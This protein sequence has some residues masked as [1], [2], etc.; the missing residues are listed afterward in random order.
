MKRIILFFIAC[1]FCLQLSA[2]TLTETQRDSILI[3]IKEATSIL[4]D[5][6]FLGSVGQYKVIPTTNSYTSLKLDTASGKISALQIGLGK[7]LPMEYQ[8]SDAVVD[9]GMILGRF[10]LYPTDNVHNF[11][12]LDTYNG[13]A[14][15]VQWSTKSEECGRWVMRGGPFTY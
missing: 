11:I 4:A 15:Q 3:R 10:D 2:Q 6:K 14:Y 1:A 8:V 7:D 9:G 12:L 13:I 5:S